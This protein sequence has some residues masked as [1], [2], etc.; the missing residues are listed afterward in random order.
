[1]VLK[2]FFNALKYASFFPVIFL[3]ADIAVKR[4]KAITSTST[5]SQP[6]S[7]QREFDN[8]DCFGM[9]S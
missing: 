5:A 8:F 1:M 3:S 7:S 6:L 9:A 2:G 4:F